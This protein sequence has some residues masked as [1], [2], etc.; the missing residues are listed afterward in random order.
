MADGEPAEPQ[1]GAT[2]MTTY[3]VRNTKSG[4]DLGTFDAA[5]PEE[6]IQAM[7]DDAG[8]TDEPSSSL[9]AEEVEADQAE[10]RTWRMDLDGAVDDMEAT[11]WA[12]A[13]AEATEWAQDGDWAEELGQFEVVVRVVGFD[14]DGD[15]EE[16]CYTVLVGTEPEEPEC[17]RDEDEDLLDHDWEDAPGAVAGQNGKIRYIE[18]CANCGVTRTTTENGSIEYRSAHDAE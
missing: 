14:K 3:T 18:R 10:P 17:V 4:L 2:T 8:C 16:R 11:D 9:V 13:K 15:E 1:P 6:A 12:A 7:L 5:T